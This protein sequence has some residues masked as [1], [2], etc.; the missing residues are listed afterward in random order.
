MWNRASSPVL[1][2]MIL[3]TLGCER[4]NVNYR[5]LAQAP[6]D[7]TSGQDM[8]NGPLCGKTDNM[9]QVK[10]GEFQMGDANGGQDYMPHTQTLA[11]FWLDQ[12]EVTVADYAKCVA[13]GACTPADGPENSSQY[14]NA[15]VA[16]KEQHPINCLDFYQASAYCAWQCKRLPTEVE[17]EYA[18][19]GTP[20]SIYPWGNEPPNTMSKPQTD[21]CWKMSNGTCPVKNYPKSSTLLGAVAGGGLY[22]MAGNVSEWT[23]SYHNCKYP[24]DQKKPADL[25]TC[26]IITDKSSRVVR[27]A[28]WN[29]PI[30]SC[31]RGA[32]RYGDGPS[33]RFHDVGFRCLGPG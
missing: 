15:G 32:Y 4:D 30:P 27:S 3:L 1:Y 16:G 19:R 23:T 2:G 29:C 22:D 17:W 12:T 20:A 5:D 25:L 7:L 24:L 33:Y 10:A 31:V 8:A 13:V 11:A 28:A 26:G 6:V 14:C 21:L 18:A 9:A